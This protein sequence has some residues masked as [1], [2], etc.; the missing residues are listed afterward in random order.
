MLAQ[1]KNPPSTL[2]VVGD[3]G[4]LSPG[5]GVIGARKATPYGRGAA[6]RFSRL[7][8][9]MGVPI[10]SGGARGCDSCAHKGALAAKGKT[11]AFLGGGC[12]RLY[13]A[14]NRAL[15]QEIVDAGGA[16]ASEQPWTQDPRPY[17]FR[18]RNR[19]IAGLSRAVLIVEAGL[20]S[21][22]FSTADDALDF[23]KEV[24][25]VPGCITSPYSAG[26]NRLLYQGATP[27]VDDETFEDQISRIFG[28]LRYTEEP[29]DNDKV[30]AVQDH[31]AF[32]I[33][34]EPEN[35]VA[36]MLSAQPMSTEKIFEAL[37]QE[38]GPNKARAEMMKLLVTAERMG[39]IERYPDGR[40]G[41]RVRG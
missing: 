10:I 41:P 12:D 24:L 25:V 15:F 23:G 27:V 40:W 33:V 18:M 28:L 2:Y 20:P 4:A 9:Q 35:P 29:P 5:L 14:E 36:V 16:I 17:M 39:S 37:S 30:G 19:L 1:L 21:G 11:I 22:T 31:A 7:A 26:A 8:A 34:T 38:W 13:P 6:S 32:R 3:V